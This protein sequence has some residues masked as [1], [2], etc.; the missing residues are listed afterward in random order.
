MPRA[1]KSKAPANKKRNFRKQRAK[2]VETKRREHA[3]IAIRNSNDG[4]GITFSPN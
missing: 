4:A 1:R 3:K 2:V